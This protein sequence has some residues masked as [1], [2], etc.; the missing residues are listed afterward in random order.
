MSRG[1]D[2][3]MSCEQGWVGLDMAPT[4]EIGLDLELCSEVGKI[5][6]FMH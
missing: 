2:L 5:S 6:K 4:I 3:N 1:A